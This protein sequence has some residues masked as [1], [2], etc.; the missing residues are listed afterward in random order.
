[1]VWKIDGTF[2]ETGA[3]SRGRNI[4][5]ML[6]FKA[7]KDDVDIRQQGLIRNNWLTAKRTIRLDAFIP[8]CLQ[9][10]TKGIQMPPDQRLFQVSDQVCRGNSQALEVGRVRLIDRS[11][12]NVLR[13]GVLR[14][15]LKN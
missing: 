2:L 12:V 8:H 3:N 15:V 7:I 5:N 13:A 10:E 14:K 11:E 9:L 6:C 1:V 4:K